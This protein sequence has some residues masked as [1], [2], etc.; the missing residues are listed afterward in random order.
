MIVG[1]TGPI[2]AGKSTVAE[3]LQRHGAIII[4]TDQL[5]RDV[6]APPSAVLDALA[7]EFGPGIV[8]A[9]G[10]LDRAAL[11]AIA[12][13]DPAKRA[14]LNALTHPAIL[15]RVLAL[16]AQQ[17]PSAVVVVVVPLL[18]ESRFQDNCNAVI[19]VVAP[20]A[21]R[22][23]R[24]QTRDGL[25]IADIDARMQAQLADEDYAREATL[26]IRNDADREELERQVD[27]A[28]RRLTAAKG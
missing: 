1:L 3:L 6:V 19:A 17:S 20:A 16:I 10:T 21:L 9:D 26:V 12:F 13:A 11:A 4:D 23:M 7:R 5:A 27:A 24:L 28:W 8:R 2:G 18:F 15:K 14:K 22:R 25:S